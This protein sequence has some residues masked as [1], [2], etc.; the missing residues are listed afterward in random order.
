MDYPKPIEDLINSFM[1]LP[2]VGRK[3]AERFALYAFSHMDESLLRSFGSN[4]INL[5]SNLCECQICH[6]LGTGSVCQICADSLRDPSSI[7]VV[8]SVKDLYVLENVG[9][10]RGVYHII[11]GLID[12]SK[13]VGANDLHIKDLLDRVKQTNVKEVI[14]ALNTTLQG[15]TTAS[16]IKALLEG[17][18]LNV[19]RLAHGI[20][21]GADISFSDEVTIKQAFEGRTKF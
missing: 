17:N 16:Y 12:F 4:L 5:K 14:L 10:Y 20:P 8:E 2:S 13:G 21:L 3:T 6:N 18:N 9:T 1:L 7:M 19:T 15:E 11:G